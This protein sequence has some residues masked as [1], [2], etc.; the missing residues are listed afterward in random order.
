MKAGKNIFLAL[1]LFFS[2]SPKRPH[3][4]KAVQMLSSLWVSIFIAL[5]DLYFHVHFNF[6]YNFFYHPREDEE[7]T[8]TCSFSWVLSKTT[9]FSLRCLAPATLQHGYFNY[10]MWLLI[11]CLK[12]IDKPGDRIQ[13][14]KCLL[15]ISHVPGSGARYIEGTK[16]SMSESLMEEPEKAEWEFTYAQ[17]WVRKAENTWRI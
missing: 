3:C 12:E 2:V 6:G 10:F 17:A 9:Q 15:I 5:F 7:Y 16:M 4:R 1:I 11:V 8:N 14:S 13:L